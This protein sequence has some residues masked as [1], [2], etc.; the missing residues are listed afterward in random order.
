[1]TTQ[2]WQ[3]IEAFLAAWWPGEFSATTSGAY[4]VALRQFDAATVTRAVEGFLNAGAKFRPS[5]AELV[6]AIRGTSKPRP[7]AEEAWSLI[8]QAVRKVGAS[9]YAQDFDERHQRAIDWLAEQDEV[10]AAYAARR[11][12]CGTGSLG[13]E[14]VNGE[15]GGAALHRVHGEYRD[16]VAAAADRQARGLPAVAEGALLVR[17][18]GEQG[19]GMVELLD[20]L[21]PDEQAQI[22]AGDES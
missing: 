2:E 22:G 5:A 21:R 7:S 20:R 3:T 1:M 12:L 19:G 16:A 13:M 9:V 4:F 18:T 10:V 11:G 14:E 6:G 15:H 17:G 8:Q